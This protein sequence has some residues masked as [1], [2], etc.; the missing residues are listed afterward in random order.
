MKC[1]YAVLF[2]WMIWLPTSLRA[3]S[4]DLGGVAQFISEAA[5]SARGGTAA[6]LDGRV[7]GIGYL[8]LRTL[9]PAGDPTV[10]YAHVGAGAAVFREGSKIK[11]EPL[12]VGMGNV[13]AIAGRLTRR[14]GWYQAHVT[15]ANLPAVFAGPILKLPM[16]G[17]KWTW[18][19]AFEVGVSIGFGGK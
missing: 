17:V 16:P 11:G 15:E 13:V 5:K 18:A 4:L 7:E 19:R 1:L 12:I 9:H 14:W 10:Q 2:A 8:P 6:N 3:Q